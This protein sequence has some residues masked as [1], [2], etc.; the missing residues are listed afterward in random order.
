[1]SILLVIL[2][3]SILA[4]SQTVGRQPGDGPRGRDNLQAAVVKGFRR[5]L[6]T[7][8]LTYKGSPSRILVTVHRYPLRAYSKHR[9]ASA[10]YWPGLQDSLVIHTVAPKFTGWKSC[11]SCSVSPIYPSSC[12]VVAL[13]TG[14]IQYFY[15]RARRYLL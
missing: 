5:H 4:M 14:C 13:T 7:V 10:P 1:M 2:W 3:P 6:E 9:G 11:T 15:T 8:Q 12:E